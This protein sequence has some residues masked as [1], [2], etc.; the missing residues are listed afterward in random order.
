MEEKNVEIST[1]QFNKNSISK[2]SSAKFNNYPVVYILHND[3]NKARAYIGET[4]QIRNRLNNHIKDKAKNSLDTAVIV[5]HAHFNQSATYNIETNLIN[6]F[7][8]D[9]KYELLNKSQITSAVTH[10]YYEKPKYNQRSEERRVGKEYRK[11]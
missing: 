7:I 1:Y 5:S 3:K 4:V 6:Y 11:Q 8:A 10:N 9:Q 2:L